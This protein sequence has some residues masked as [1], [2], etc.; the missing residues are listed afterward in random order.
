MSEKDLKNYMISSPAGSG[1]TRSLTER[2]VNLLLSM[3]NPDPRRIL[4]M[5]FTNDAASEMRTRIIEKIRIEHPDLYKKIYRNLTGLRIQTIHSFSRQL[6]ERFAFELGFDPGIA[7]LEDPHHLFINVFRRLLQDDL[8]KSDSPILKLIIDQGAKFSK[9][10]KK[11]LDLLDERPRWDFC[12]KDSMLKA[13]QNGEF[14]QFALFFHVLEAFQQEKKILGYIDFNDMEAFAYDLLYNH[15]E[16]ALVLEAFDEATDHLLVDEFQDTNLLQWALISKL[17]QEWRSGYG[18]K[19]ERGIKPTIFI[20]GD[21]NQSIFMFRGAN[22]EVFHQAKEELSAFLGEDFVFHVRSENYRSLK[23]I[24]DFVNYLFPK[25]L[26]GSDSIPWKTSYHAFKKKREVDAIGNVVILELDIPKNESPNL[27]GLRE[28]EAKSIARWILYYLKDGYIYNDDGIKRKPEYKDIAILVR[29]RSPLYENALEELNIPYISIEE[30]GFYEAPEIQ[31]LLALMKILLY[32]TDTKS[33]YQ[34][35][36]S[37]LGEKIRENTLK[38]ILESAKADPAKAFGMLLKE[39]PQLQEFIEAVEQELFS[40]A[41]N[42]FLIQTGFFQYL[43]SPQEHENV[44]RLFDILLDLEAKGQSGREIAYSIVSGQ[45]GRG[46]KP[47]VVDPDLNAVTITTI[48]KAKGLQWPIVII[49]IFSW[50]GRFSPPKIGFEEK[51]NHISGYSVDITTDENLLKEKY[52]EEEKRLLYVACTR[53]RDVLTLTFVPDSNFNRTYSAKLIYE[54]IMDLRKGTKKI[55]GLVFLSEKE[56]I[57][58]EIPIK[59]GIKPPKIKSEFTSP[60]NLLA[61]PIIKFMS[62]EKGDTKEIEP[63]WLI[64]G[65][66]FHEGVALL[67]RGR[68]RD[69]TQLHDWAEKYFKNRILSESEQ[70]HLIA[71]FNRHLNNLIRAPIVGDIIER[72]HKGITLTEFPVLMKTES[73]ENL[74]GRVDLILISNE[75]IKLFDYK[76]IPVK[77]RIKE[78]TEYYRFQ[79]ANYKKAIRLLFQKEVRGY[80]VFTDTGELVEVE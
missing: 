21:E 55:E 49:P 58:P 22:V 6:I 47:Q 20:V 66:A 15:D 77:G 42:R 31:T 33:L 16:W 53:A 76:T 44:D 27:E 38:E 9:I 68:I 29:N 28:I 73:G 78:L 43:G 1:K 46:E 39:L 79:I 24:I 80:L 19:T 11:L 30:R 75:G 61:H 35:L 56:G 74:S 65:N 14:E 45:A 2:F 54:G 64:F 25:I 18:A 41:L 67:I 36:A 60:V 8:F 71:E 4:A 40:S 26:T 10:E 32:P 70:E 7:V 72:N 57:F 69:R 51:F 48:H 23:S 17:T 34:I 62:G 12:N 37:P 59:K 13:S 3:K 5:T 52:L 50:R 63:K